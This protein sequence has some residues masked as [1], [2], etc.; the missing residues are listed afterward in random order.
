MSLA[1]SASSSLAVAKSLTF[2]SKDRDEFN[3]STIV[4]M[5]LMLEASRPREFTVML[6]SAC[7]TLLSRVRMRPSTPFSTLDAG[8]L[9]SFKRPTAIGAAVGS[10]PGG[11]QPPRQRG[12][13]LAAGDA[14]RG[15]RVRR[16]DRGARPRSWYRRRRSTP[17]LRPVLPGRCGPF[18]ARIGSRTRDRR[19]RGPRPRGCRAGGQ[20]ARRRCGDQP[21]A[22]T[23]GLGPTA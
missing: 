20:C 18:P 5:G 1:V 7:G 16:S 21:G 6:A 2:N 4:S 15:A 14:D 11:R 9:T 10:A 8:V 22:P 13:V 23:V 17:G 12:Q 19:P 3:I